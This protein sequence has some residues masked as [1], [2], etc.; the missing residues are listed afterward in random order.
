MQIGVL[1]ETAPYE[2]RVALTP[3][4]AARLIAAGH[5]IHVQSGAGLAADE[6][7]DA[8]RRAGALIGKT[9][10]EIL[11]Y[12]D[13]LATVGQLDQQ[14]AARM[15]P[16][17]AVIGLVSPKEGRGPAGVL[18]GRHASFFALE[19]LPRITRAQTMDALSS[20]AMVA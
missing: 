7:D 19:L 9:P 12:V 16:G 15:T 17:T 14:T 8:F 6:D 5:G 2:R 1:T 3:E 11:G 18:V 4:S 13:L 20:Q 10:E